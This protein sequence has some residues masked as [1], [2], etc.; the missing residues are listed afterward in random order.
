M[1]KLRL[2]SAR[3]LFSAPF[4]KA[5]HV[6]VVRVRSSKVSTPPL[7]SHRVGVPPVSS[8]QSYLVP[9]GNSV[10]SDWLHMCALP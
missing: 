8:F 4:G 5:L 10:A 2:I 3:V 6:V 7:P 1:I 9:S